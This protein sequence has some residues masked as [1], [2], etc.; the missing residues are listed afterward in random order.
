MFSD[1]GYRDASRNSQPWLRGF[2]V[3][4]VHS[5]D[6]LLVLYSCDSFEPS[7]SAASL[8]SDGCFTSLKVFLRVLTPKTLWSTM[9]RSPPQKT[10]L[11]GFIG[12]TVD[13]CYTLES[14]SSRWLTLLISAVKLKTRCN[15][16]LVAFLTDLFSE[17]LFW[18]WGWKV[19]Q[20][21]KYDKHL[22]NHLNR[23]LNVS[24]WWETF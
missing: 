23:Y 22:N 20:Y 5:I 9:N 2:P 19:T 12:F 17:S 8:C 16:G 24:G 21:K 4:L 14:L 6:T 10:K 3:K 11:N 7:P 1:I 18:V 15:T 13:H